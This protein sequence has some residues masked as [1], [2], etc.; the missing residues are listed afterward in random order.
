MKTQFRKI[1]IG[2]DFSDAS[3]AGARW[4]SH[5]LAPRA[6]LLLVHVVP[7]P[8]PPVYLHEHIGSTIDQRSTLVPR[9]Y[10]AL[11]GFADLLNSDRVRVGIRTG[12]PWSALARVADEVKADLICVGRGPKRRGS[13][14]F[15][16]TTPQ[17]LLAI[18]Q[19]PV[20][21]IPQG[22]VSKPGR[23]FAALSGRPGGERVIALANALA[24]GWGS[25]LEAIHVIEADVHQVSRTSTGTLGVTD[26]IGTRSVDR[27][28]SIGIDA[29]D[30]SALHMLASE[31]VALT[32]SAADATESD[33]PMIRIG[34]AGQELITMAR[35]KPG[36]SVI[37]IGR[38]AETLPT[39]PSRAEYRCGSTTRMVLWAAPCPVFVVPMEP[40]VARSLPF[41][42]QTP[43]LDIR[44]PI[45]AEAASRLALL[46]PTGW[47]PSGGDDAA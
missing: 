34:D 8:R 33:D 40:G 29:L 5:H 4:V 42:A 27:G 31:W 46:S 13:S 47:H 38:V 37:V 39:P 30:Q 24:A 35:E 14:R 16:A 20:L 12:V 36:S 3:L 15:G 22:V 17:R 26:W 25:R 19:V 7:V 10:T 23:V 2:I 11:R 6:E 43:G 9:L 32:V 44:L 45:P 1:V 28:R 18:S 21:V 41:S